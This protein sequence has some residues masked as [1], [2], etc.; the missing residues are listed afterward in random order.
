MVTEL[1]PGDKVRIGSVT[2]T[3][4]PAL[5]DGR[6]D[7]LGPSAEAIGYVVS[8][9]L[10]CVLRGGHR[11]LRRDGGARV[12]PR[13]GPPARLGLGTQPGAGASRS[14][15]GPPVRSRCCVPA[16]PY[17]STGEPCSRWACPGCGRKPCGSRRSCSR[18]TPPGSPRTL[19]CASSPRAR[20]RSSIGRRSR[21]VRASEPRAGKRV[22]SSWPRS[23]PGGRSAP[24][25]PRPRPCRDRDGRRRRRGSRTRSPSRPCAGCAPRS[26]PPLPHASSAA[27][28]S[29]QLVGLAGL[30]LPV[31]LGHRPPVEL[32]GL[33]PHDLGEARIRMDDRRVGDANQVDPLRGAVEHERLKAHLLLEPGVPGHVMPGQDEPSS[34]Q[35]RGAHVH[36]PP[37]LPAD[38]RPR[39]G[40]RTP[41]ASPPD[42]GRGR[43]AASGRRQSPRYSGNSWQSVCP[44]SFSRG[45]PKSFRAASFTCSIRKSTTAPRSSRTAR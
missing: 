5:H 12:S 8:G 24:A 14:R 1:T 2:I 20:P 42:R 11:P 4:V 9:S 38:A 32:A 30:V 36:R 29:A 15:C 18:R 23:P 26:S 37:E 44:T 28:R 40:E 13:R 22:R 25:A 10:R 45:R 43:L 3:A 41:P 19:M 7:P 33:V 6:R 34:A 35:R 17:P 31:D 27:M 21:R 16:S 39:P